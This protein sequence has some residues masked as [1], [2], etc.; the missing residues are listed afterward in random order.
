MKN[1]ISVTNPGYRDYLIDRGRFD[2]LEGTEDPD[3]PM[4]NTDAA[5]PADPHSTSPRI[6]GTVKWF[7]AKKGFGFILRTDGE[8]DV[9][10]HSTDAKKSGIADDLEEGDAVSFVLAATP[11]GFKATH[12]QRVE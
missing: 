2:L 1:M 11:R 12:L 10:F 5:P 8:K 4:T 6:P 7:D 9:F 3:H